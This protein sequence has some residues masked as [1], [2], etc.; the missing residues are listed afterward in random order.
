VSKTTA[1]RSIGCSALACP[2]IARPRSRW[3]PLIRACRCQPR[4]R[5]PKFSCVPRGA[6]I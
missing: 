5:T 6:A 4:A 1:R 3:L 2:A